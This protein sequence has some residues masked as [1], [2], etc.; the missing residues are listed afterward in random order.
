M[1]LTTIDC[2]NHGTAAI[3]VFSADG[4]VGV[5]GMCPEAVVTA[6]RRRV[7]SAPRARSVV[8]RRTDCGPG[9]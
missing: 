9:T 3:G 1:P 5:K 4:E 8:G 2:V 6:S 7:R